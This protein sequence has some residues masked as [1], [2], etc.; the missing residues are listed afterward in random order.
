MPRLTRCALGCSVHTGWAA[1]VAVAGS[2][3]APQVLLRE[4][5]ELFPGPNRFVYHRAALAGPAEAERIVAKARAVAARGAADGL[6]RLMAQARA[7]GAEPVACVIV[8]NTKDLPASVAEIVAAHPKMH[9]AE[10][11]L[12]RD[13]L[14]EAARA[15]G[16][17]LRIVAPRE[18]EALQP[19]ATIERVGKLV[20]RPWSKD[21]R[22][23]AF[24]A[25]A[26]LAARG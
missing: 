25:W 15:G 7:A 21:H 19:K 17:R 18:A 12:Y 5:V 16:L 11:A 26:A 13:A 22:L 24:A 8:A 9:A 10:G 2:V 6:R 23:A 3:G 14:A 20:G 4:R 1:C